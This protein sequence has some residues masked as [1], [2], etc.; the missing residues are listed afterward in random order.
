MQTSDSG[1]IA[2]LQ[3]GASP[4]LV[5]MLA[6][7]VLVALLPGLIARW[8]GVPD[9]A[10]ISALGLLSVLVPPLWLGVMAWAVLAQP[11]ATARA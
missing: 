3:Q 6:L 11:R 2:T 7:A 9:A 8:R 1:L 4:V 5:F 10:K